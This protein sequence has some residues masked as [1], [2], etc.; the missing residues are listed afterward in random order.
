MNLSF[1]NTSPFCKIFVKEYSFHPLVNICMLIISQ[2][3]FNYFINEFL[4]HFFV[5]VMV[6]VIEGFGDWGYLSLVLYK[7][8]SLFPYELEY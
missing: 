8:V 2:I 7:T 3:C 4:N 6:N 5:L 1:H